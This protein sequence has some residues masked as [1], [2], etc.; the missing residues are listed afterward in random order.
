MTEKDFEKYTVF[1]QQDS[2]DWMLLRST[3]LIERFN[4]EL[5]RR[6]KP[7]GGMTN[8]RTLVKLL[9]GVATAQQ[10]RWNRIKV[11][12]SRKEVKNQAA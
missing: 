12:T 2:K 9:W 6:F 7:V 8:E 11:H 4:R 1:F 5:R 10:E 3:N